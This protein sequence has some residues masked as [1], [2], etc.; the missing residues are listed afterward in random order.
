[1]SAAGLHIMLQLACMRMGYIRKGAVW[2]IKGTKA[3]EINLHWGVVLLCLLVYT[4][5]CLPNLATKHW[6]P[7]PCRYMRTQT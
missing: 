3:D 4:P 6:P 5:S 2:M 7:L 1:M